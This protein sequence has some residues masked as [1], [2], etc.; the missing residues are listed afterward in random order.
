[1]TDTLDESQ[2]Q[3][4]LDAYRVLDSLPE[5]AYDDIVTLAAEIC[6]TPIA[7]VS[8]IDRDR[9][10]L[11]ARFGM[12]T[13][14]TS[15]RVAFCDHAIRS[16]D[17][18]MQVPD[19]TQDP[20]FSD[21]PYVTDESHIRFYAGMP[22]VTPDGAAIG[23]V[24]VIDHEPRELTEGQK[25]ALACLARLT[26]TLLENRH[27]EH[28]QARSAVL[29]QAEVV[30]PEAA[31]HPGRTVALLELQGY[32]GAV[33]R[34]GER[35]VERD[36]QRLEERIDAS[37]DPRAGDRVSRVTGSAELILVLHGDSAPALE[38]LDAVVARFE[39]ETSL[40]VLLAHAS[41]ESPAERLDDVFLRADAALS[42]AKDAEREVA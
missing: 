33:A 22:L 23:T 38:A 12:D 29:A 39:Q 5:A 26:M 13:T 4:A 10:W 31:P 17:H 18:L 2:R 36:L 21:N 37:L 28:D 14:E 25:S 3:R 6:D 15:R 20:R 9:Q 24:C 19:A 11:K 30:P 7:L 32:A 34:K 41:A 1:M 42:A 16:P 27:R 8:L 35:S 40:H